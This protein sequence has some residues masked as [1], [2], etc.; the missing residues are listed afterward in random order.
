MAKNF[1]MVIEGGG[2]G[3]TSASIGFMCVICGGSQNI[4][5]YQAV[6]NPPICNKCLTDLREIIL[7][8]RKQSSNG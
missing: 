5:K 7:E 3:G 4:I 8:K 6:P 1:D 2:A